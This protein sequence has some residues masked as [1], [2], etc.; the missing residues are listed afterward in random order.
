MSCLDQ[1]LRMINQGAKFESDA[2]MLVSSTRLRS[3]K[4]YL[5]MRTVMSRLPQLMMTALEGAVVARLHI[6]RIDCFLFTCAGSCYNSATKKKKDFDTPD[7]TMYLSTHLMGHFGE[8]HLRKGR[9]VIQT[10]CQVIYTCEIEI[11]LRVTQP[12]TVITMSHSINEEKTDWP[13]LLSEVN[14]T[15]WNVIAVHLVWAKRVSYEINHF[16]NN[17]H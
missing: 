4:E 5:K 10:T 15:R 3:R 2:K 13:W 14:N 9:S 17:Q 12:I 16:V 6:F 1:V 8:R 11:R 7:K